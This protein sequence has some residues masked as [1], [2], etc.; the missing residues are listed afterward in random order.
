M[1]FDLPSERRVRG[2][3]RWMHQ[4]MWLLF[5]VF[6][7]L[8]VLARRDGAMSGESFWI[9][10]VVLL[11]FMLSL[12]LR[13]LKRIAGHRNTEDKLVNEVKTFLQKES[14]RAPEASRQTETAASVTA[15][16]SEDCN[17][18]PRE[19]AQFVLAEEPIGFREPCGDLA[20]FDAF[21]S[22]RLAGV[23]TRFHAVLQPVVAEC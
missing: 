9:P 2:T 12:T 10:S 5:A 17:K 19:A 18:V 22:R 21:P 23:K 3:T 8:M 15:S 20:V 4:A 6:M 14:V 7:A 11:A 13:D 1:T 16:A